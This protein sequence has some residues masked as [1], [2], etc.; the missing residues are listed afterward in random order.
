[1][2]RELFIPV[3][4]VTIVSALLTING[5]FGF[6][7]L[8]MALARPT[9]TPPGGNIILS[10]PSGANGL[11]GPAGPAG[12]I[13]PAG[14]PGPQG[15]RGPDGPVG[16]AGPPGATGPEGLPGPA[17]PIRSP[18][19]TIDTL[20]CVDIDGSGCKTGPLTTNG[21]ITGATCY[22]NGGESMTTVNSLTANSIDCSCKGRAGT[23]CWAALITTR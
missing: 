3:I 12:P 22:S 1:M 2:N 18:G 10:G 9:Q 23:I 11:Q 15:A 17:G 6:S 13:G 4:S 21:T 16:P 20:A 19:G 8:E 5:A 14:L 7:S